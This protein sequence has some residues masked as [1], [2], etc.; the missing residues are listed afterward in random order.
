MMFDCTSDMILISVKGGFCRYALFPP[1]SEWKVNNSERASFS[2]KQPLFLNALL[3][4]G[5]DLQLH[6]IVAY[7]LTRPEALRTTVQFKDVS[8]RAAVQTGAA[9]INIPDVIPGHAR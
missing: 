7:V 9:D 8:E 1:R 5:L 3:K 4:N 6:P 2:G